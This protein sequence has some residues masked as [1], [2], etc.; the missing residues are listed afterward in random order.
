MNLLKLLFKPK[1]NSFQRS[2]S[3]K[4]YSSQLKIVSQKFILG[5]ILTVYEDQ[6][7]N[8]YETQVP[9]IMLPIT[10]ENK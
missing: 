5:A 7:G 3:G 2:E 10:N 1:I 8:R 4:N 9:S 6:E